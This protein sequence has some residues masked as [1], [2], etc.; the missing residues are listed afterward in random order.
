MQF[1][2]QLE[3]LID[4]IVPSI[5][6]IFVI[7][8]II[9]LLI[10]IFY[11]S[12]FKK[13]K[14]N[15]Y[16]IHFRRGKVKRAG[17]GGTVILWPVFDEVVIIPTTVQQ[18]L[19][20]AREKV[21]SYEYQDVALTAFVYWRVTNP[22][23]SFSKVSWDPHRTDYVEKAIKNA[24]EAIIRTTCANMKIEQIIRNRAEI[25]K[26]VTTE[27]HAL[28]GDWG[29]T[30]ESIEIRD[31]EV[32]DQRLKDNLEAVKKIEEAQNAQLRQAEMEESVQLRNLDVRQKTGLSD[33]EVKLSIESKA[34]NREIQIA[35]LEQERAIIA[36]E[37][38]RK[39]KQ[40]NAEAEKFLRVTQEVGVEAERIRQQAE[41]RK[42]QLLAEAE[43]E[44]AKITQ[45]QVA[46]AKGILEQAKALSQA[47]EKYIQ[48]KTL[49]MLPEVFKN[50]N[51]DRMILLGE[52]QDAYK[53]VAQMI[54]PFMELA[55]EVGLTKELASASNPSEKKKRKRS[56]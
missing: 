22:E 6:I 10:I 25:I 12:R 47:D 17:T 21:V 41:A 32:L 40:I 31:V 1:F 50:I 24:T 43:G 37:T 42:D 13:F 51:V 14:T 38:E 19:L 15:E 34:K 29:I 26:N 36:A 20:E 8:F 5:G 27:L 23:I 28:S 46:L 16:V 45:T 49:D 9:F 18:T 56:E 52:G 2:L 3:S 30:I 35:Q 11:V 53:S 55:K 7:G 39:Q 54:L 33:Q 4:A 48:L 44:A